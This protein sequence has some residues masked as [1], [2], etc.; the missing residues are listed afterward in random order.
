LQGEKR[1][2]VWLA[3]SDLA[4]SVEQIDKL[5]RQGMHM[6][7]LRQTPV[8]AEPSEADYA[9]FCATVMASGRGRWFLAEYARRHRK[10]DTDAV[11]AALHRIEDM[12]RAGPAADPLAR[13]RDE[14]RALA[15]MVRQ[16]RGGLD[17]PNAGLSSAAKMMA[18]LDLLEQRIE[19]SL[20][21]GDDR[22]P[23]PP[24]ADGMADLEPAAGTDARPDAARAHL[25]IIAA[26]DTPQLPAEAVWFPSAS[27]LPPLDPADA[28][29]NLVVLARKNHNLPLHMPKAAPSRE[30]PPLNTSPHRLFAVSGRAAAPPSIAAAAASQT[31]AK[32]FADVMA[33]SDAERIALFS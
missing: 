27:L 11:L 7:P 33:L 19:Y 17:T 25:S 26:T 4:E 32:R 23:L 6:E 13:L 9:E 24:P 5:G 16:A 15:A 8:A 18:L 28:G 21:P 20:A 1:H 12:V 14:L 29:P 3:G 22:A 31:I 30:L 2:G 10:A